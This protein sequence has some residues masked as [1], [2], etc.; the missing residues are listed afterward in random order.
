MTTLIALLLEKSYRRKCQ[1][2]FTLIEL[3]V[4]IAI[5]AILAAILFP[6]FA[7]AKASAI[8]SAS[9]SN[10]KQLATA[11]LMYS[12][13]YDDMF[14]IGGQWFSPDTDA[15]HPSGGAIGYMPWTGLIYPYSKS[16]SITD[17]PHVGPTAVPYNYTATNNCQSR[18]QCSLLYPTYGYNIAYL[19]PTFYAAPY[20]MTS[21]AQTSAASP[22]SLV[23]LTEIWSPNR[24]QWGG[25]T[26]GTP[27]FYVSIA[28]A[29]PPECNWSTD[30]SEPVCMD[31]WGIRPTRDDRLRTAEEGAGTGGVAFRNSN[32][33][34]TAFAD[35]HVKRV[36][37]EELAKGTSWRRNV[38]LY[39]ETVRVGSGYMWD[40][41][42]Q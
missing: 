2:A 27:Y 25:F 29:E 16:L 6:V 12:S 8:A 33:T 18:R 1:K 42:T 20:A 24:S 19:S 35:G 22:S 21:T 41:R 5:I 23:L 14:V 38:T 4:V 17:S 37:A 30:A 36:T 28:S 3:L 10:V 32:R 31:S 39:G 40:P 7:R 26:G 34:P 9:L 11:E 13:D 15:C